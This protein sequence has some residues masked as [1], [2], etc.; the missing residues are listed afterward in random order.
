MQ[1]HRP[2]IGLYL[3]LAYT[4][5]TPKVFGFKACSATKGKE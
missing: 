2:E 4:F 1:K 5:P 3:Y